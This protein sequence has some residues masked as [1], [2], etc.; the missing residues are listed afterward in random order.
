M[1]EWK[2]NLSLI[3]SDSVST[4]FCDQLTAAQWC[5]C[6]SRCRCRKW[7]VSRCRT[8]CTQ[9]FSDTNLIITIPHMAL[10]LVRK[11]KMPTRIFSSVHSNYYRGPNLSV[12]WWKK[13]TL[14]PT[15]PPT[16]SSALHS[17]LV[18]NTRHSAEAHCVPH[19]HISV[20]QIWFHSL[21]YVSWRVLYVVKVTV[22]VAPW[23]NA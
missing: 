14:S 3:S 9:T 18:T 20:M 19:H 12:A 17:Q 23:A 2:N 8:S 1:R 16:S 13:I 22:A 5:E 15:W 4:L 11:V 6:L 21:I 7:L 10:C